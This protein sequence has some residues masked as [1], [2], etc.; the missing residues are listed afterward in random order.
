[1]RIGIVG[2]SGFIG[3]E[4]AKEAAAQ[5]HT[6]IGF[7]RSTR[8]PEPPFE[9]WRISG[10]SYDLRNL[11]VVI[12]L[13]GE[14][15]DQRWTDELKEKFRVSRVDATLDI[16][17]SLGET[18]PEKRPSC[19]INGSAVGIYGNRQDEI[20][21]EES[22]SGEGYLADLT[23]DWEKA[24]RGA[25]LHDVRL[26]CMRIGIVL[27]QE[28][29][30]YQKLEKVFKSGVGGRLGDGEQ[31]MPWIHVKDLARAFLFV[32]EQETIAGPVNGTAPYPEKNKD[33]TKKFARAFLLPALFPV[34]GFALKIVMGDF[35]GALL[36]GQRAVPEILEK[37][38]FE[39]RYPTLEDAMLDLKTS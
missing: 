8:K 33:F 34:P 13:A 35:G 18:R 6:I 12:N 20:L 25:T 22:V 30:A 5:G 26:A 32:A 4:L 31:W 3:Q 1:M 7:S 37:H 38:G 16:V 28:G 10:P 23:A 21:T 36:A 2:A 24:A 19:L 39:F 14:A 15:I 27:G 9:E 11:D 29:A 17:R